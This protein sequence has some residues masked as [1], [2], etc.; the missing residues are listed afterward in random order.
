MAGRTSAALI[1][2]LRHARPRTCELVR[3]LLCEGAELGQA[4]P[5]GVHEGC[6]RE[7]GPA[8]REEEAH[9]VD[10]LQQRAVVRT[11]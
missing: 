4:A 1:R 8:A 11:V 5:D 10:R 6:G 3:V 2:P 9:G 7:D